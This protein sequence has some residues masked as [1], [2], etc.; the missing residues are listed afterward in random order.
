MNSL[1]NNFYYFF[2]YKLNF[3]L[4]L[5][6]FLKIYSCLF[7]FFPSKNLLLKSIRVSIFTRNYKLLNIFYAQLLNYNIFK[8]QKRINT[9]IIFYSLNKQIKLVKINILIR[10]I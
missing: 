10:K 2:L 4:N 7:F 5:N 1:I 9:E 8:N 3:K 6:F